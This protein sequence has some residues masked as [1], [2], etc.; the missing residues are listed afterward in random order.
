MEFITTTR[1]GRQLLRDS[2]LYYKNTSLN[3]QSSYWEYKGRS[4][5]GCKVKIFLDEKENFSHEF[6][7]QMHAPNSETVS[8]LNKMKIDARVTDN[9]TN[10]IITT[11]IGGMHEVLVKLSCIDT[12]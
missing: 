10:N 7:E 5:N 4:G 3:N 8:A 12:I 11:N 9:T 6:G 1:G 2:Y